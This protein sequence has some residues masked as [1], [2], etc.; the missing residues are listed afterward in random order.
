MRPCPCGSGA[1]LDDCCGP[2]LGGAAAPTAE[3]LM[4]SRYAAHVL[5]DFDH[6]QRTHAPETRGGFDRAAAERQAGGVEWLG[7]E[8][9]AA[10]AGGASDDAGTVEFT[11][12]YREGGQARAFREVSRFR[13]E[14]GRWVYVDGLPVPVAAAP[15]AAKVGRN[16]PCPCGSGRKFKKCCGA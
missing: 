13:R 1:S 6:L 8:I 2:V 7:L 9:H 11:A 16:D 15:K 10:G 5:R 14:Q 4:R 12:R 3:A